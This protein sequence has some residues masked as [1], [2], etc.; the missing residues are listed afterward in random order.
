MNLIVDLVLD[1]TVMAS[2]LII[3][4]TVRADAYGIIHEVAARVVLT[5]G[6][7]R[8]FDRTPPRTRGD[9]GCAVPWLCHEGRCRT[10]VLQIP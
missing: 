2:P 10:R 9:L 3:E 8:K 4:V 5:R 6:Y 7:D 1:R